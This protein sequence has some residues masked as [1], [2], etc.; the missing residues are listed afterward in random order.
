MVFLACKQSESRQGRRKSHFCCRAE[1]CYSIYVKFR[2]ESEQFLRHTHTG[3]NLHRSQTLPTPRLS[4][5][6]RRRLF[7]PPQVL[8]TYCTLFTLRSTSQGAHGSTQLFKYPGILYVGIC[9]TTSR[10]RAVQAS[11]TSGGRAVTKKLVYSDELRSHVLSLL[12]NKRTST[13]TSHPPHHTKTSTHLLRQQSQV[14]SPH[15]KKK[16]RHETMQRN[17][18]H[19]NTNDNAVHREKKKNEK[20]N[21]KI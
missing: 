9:T 18:R 11:P 7:R 3:G 1:N 21:P 12:A 6:S 20:N 17:N 2:Q 8:H 19:T 4:L 13:R 16:K 5:L 10:R 14:F 15:H